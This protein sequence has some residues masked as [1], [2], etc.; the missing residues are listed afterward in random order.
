MKKF[1]FSVADAYFYRSNS[2]ELIFQSKTLV[3][4]SIEATISNEDARAGKGNTLQFVYY[5]SSELNVTLTEQQFNMAMLAPS[6]GAY[7]ITGDIIQNSE[8]VTLEAGGKGTV[9][10]GMPINSKYVTAET[11]QGSV[12]VDEEITTVTFTGQEFTFPNG[13]EGDTVCVIY[14]MLSPTTTSI[15]V[16]ANMI[17]SVG[18]LVLKAQLGSSET[19][20]AETT[21][22]VIGEVEIEIPSLQLNPSGI[23]MQ[24]TS[25]GISQSQLSGRAL[26]FYPATGGCTSSGV[27]ATIKETIYG[28]GK[29]DNV[30]ALVC[31]NSDILISGGA[32]G[33][34]VTMELLCVPKQGSPFKP[35]YA[36]VTFVS[37]TI[38]TATVGD[39]TGI[40]TPAAAGTTVVTATIEREIGGNLV[41][42][43]S[44]EVEA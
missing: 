36:D 15:T 42:T 30:T 33:D 39:H 25:S 27:Y 6:V 8:E 28:A 23:G 43:A 1:L 40:I 26:A 14:N 22:S 34:P 35:D 17:P 12:I 44:V 7:L 11:V 41:A 3:D 9:T 37:E 29:Y 21:S 13:E 32:G 2:N 10:G 20:Q 31:T 19:G 38:G 16:D 24:M 4:S 5:H 18:R